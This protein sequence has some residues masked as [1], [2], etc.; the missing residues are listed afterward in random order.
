MKILQIASISPNFDEALTTSHGVTRLWL[1]DEPEREID[2]TAAGTE[3][4]VTRSSI[5][6]D[7]RLIERLPDLRA[8]CTY[9]VGYETIDLDAARERGVVVSN[10]PDVLTDCVADLAMGL[11]LA[12]ARRIPLYDR[13]VRTGQWIRQSAPLSRSV[14]RKRLGIVG[15]GRIGQAVARRAAGFDISVAYNGPRRVPDALPEQRFEPS[16]VD[17]ARWADFLVVS[18]IGGESTRRLISR[19]V[20]DALGPEGT[21]VNITRGS[22]VD[23]PALVEALQEGRLGAAALDVFE[24]EPNVPE[25][26]FGLDNVVLSPHM[27]SGTIETRQRMEDLVAE[28]VAEFSRTGRLVSEVG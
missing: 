12:S 24:D 17:L 19:E 25:V 8:I 28:N 3:L 22:V 27:A 9:G 2:R 6:A 23:E 5:G 21:L 10:T 18:C 15:L 1:A 26:L 4:I 7:R 16:L 11:L 20:I 14:A 13:F